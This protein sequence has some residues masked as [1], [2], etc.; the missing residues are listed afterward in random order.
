MQQVII[1]K[2]YRE[3]WLISRLFQVHCLRIPPID[4]TEDLISLLLKANSRLAV[5]ESVATRIPNSIHVCP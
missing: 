2:I 4:M 5:L 3:K 1:N